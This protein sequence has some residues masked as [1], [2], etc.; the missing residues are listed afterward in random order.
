MRFQRDW[1]ILILLVSYE[2]KKNVLGHLKRDE[3]DQTV[4]DVPPPVP[5]A[6]VFPHQKASQ[7][8][9]FTFEAF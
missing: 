5:G 2:K 4:N 9:F 7:G 3:R 6:K 8:E 1:A